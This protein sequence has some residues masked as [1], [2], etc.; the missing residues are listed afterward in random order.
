VV[1]DYEMP[2][3]IRSWGVYVPEEAI[4]RVAEVLKSGWINTGKHEKELRDLFRKK[5]L[6]AHCVAVN[7][8]TAALRASYQM[9]G[10]GHGDEVVTTP[11]T[12]IATNTSLLEQGA[13]PVF[14]D[15]RY[16]DLND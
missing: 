5:F 7:N 14:A 12:F 9:L 15:I 8:G 3:D 13:I 6:V 1:K 11:Y 2:N 10:I 16:G 4:E